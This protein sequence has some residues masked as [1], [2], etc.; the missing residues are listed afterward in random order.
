[1][2]ITKGAFEAGVLQ[3]IAARGIA[4]ARIVAASSGALN[5]TAY[6]AGVRARRERAAAA[7]LAR[8]WRQRG[9]LCD[10]LH[11]SLGDILRCR[12]L[13]DQRRLRAILRDNV[14]PSRIADPAPIEIHLITAPLHGCMTTVQGEAV[15]SYTR[16]V[17]FDGASFDARET[18]EQ[19]F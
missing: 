11:P 5:G 9:G 15:T 4:V 18:L 8:L 10:V 7:D 3:V 17:R 1:G 16:V 14:R 13:S 12:G 2:A 19:V 6:A